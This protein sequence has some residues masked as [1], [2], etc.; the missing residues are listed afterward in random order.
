M[1]K[2][3]S[4][5]EEPVWVWSF[6]AVF[7]Q[8]NAPFTP[9]LPSAVKR[10]AVLASCFNCFQTLTASDMSWG[11]NMKGMQQKKGVQIMKRLHGLNM[12]SPICLGL[13]SF[14]GSYRH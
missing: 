4:D 3:N 10:N 9:V 5:K 12:I 11:T 2:Q 14:Q 8:S 7:H 1:A 13:H 6:L